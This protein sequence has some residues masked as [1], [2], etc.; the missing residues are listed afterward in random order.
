MIF[1]EVATVL[2]SKA[3]GA[4]NCQNSWNA[5]FQNSR[6]FTFLHSKH[7]W[8][9]VTLWYPCTLKL[10]TYIPQKPS[11]SEAVRNRPAAEAQKRP[12]AVGTAWDTE[13]SI[14][15]CC[16]R[17]QWHEGSC[18]A[19]R[20]PETCL[21]VIFPSHIFFQ[22]HHV[23][24]CCET[25]YLSGAVDLVTSYYKDLKLWASHANGL[26]PGA[27][28]RVK[29]STSVRQLSARPW[30]WPRWS[31]GWW[32]IVFNVF[33]VFNSMYSA[34]DKFWN[35]NCPLTSFFVGPNSFDNHAS[36]LRATKWS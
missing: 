20:N 8:F 11:R 35:L 32:W 10:N 23:P 16:Q 28:L 12:A 21:L 30:Q 26:G 15:A 1:A 4:H 9:H 25:E 3:A 17:H 5:V 36:G 13:F 18:C 33:I 34:W 29:T 22:S 19:R 2:T 24:K 6:L 31:G 27:L 7:V 14:W